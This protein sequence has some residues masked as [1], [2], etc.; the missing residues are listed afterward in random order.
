MRADPIPCPNVISIDWRAGKTQAHYYYYAHH[1][2][3]QAFK[4]WRGG[5][6]GPHDR[7][8]LST[9]A[10]TSARPTLFHHLLPPHGNA[11][12]SLRSHVPISRSPP[13]GG[14]TW[15]CLPQHVSINERMHFVPLEC[16][17]VNLR[18]IHDPL[19]LKTPKNIRWRTKQSS[20]SDDRR[21]P[22]FRTWGQA[23]EAGSVFCAETS[24]WLILLNYNA[25]ASCI[26]ASSLVP[27]RS[28]RTFSLFSFYSFLKLFWA[29]QKAHLTSARFDC[30]LS[31]LFQA[32]LRSLECLRCSSRFVSRLFCVFWFLM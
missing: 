14:A 27:M 11:P 1:A 9:M 17:T 25:D 12:L 22:W 3:R 7:H 8:A 32:L 31:L 30:V 19:H 29:V 18:F 21:R 28:R 4:T 6:S 5:G 2:P 16:L 13:A 20:T 26:H 24:R 15:T 10:A 23:C